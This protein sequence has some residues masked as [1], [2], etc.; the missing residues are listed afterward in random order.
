MLPVKLW[1]LPREHNQVV[2]DLTLTNHTMLLMILTWLVTIQ[3]NLSHP[4]QN[5]L[6]YVLLTLIFNCLLLNHSLP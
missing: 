5:Y 1:V 3:G 6:K 4:I 2:D